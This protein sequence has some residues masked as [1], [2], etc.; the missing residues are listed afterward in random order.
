M[1]EKVEKALQELQEEI[2]VNVLFEDDMANCEMFIINKLDEYAKKNDIKLPVQVKVTRKNN[3]L[4][5]T[6]LDMGNV[7]STLH[8]QPTE[9]HPKEG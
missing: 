7:L 3:K 6:V 9:L 2:K 4:T 1:K 5:I 8:I